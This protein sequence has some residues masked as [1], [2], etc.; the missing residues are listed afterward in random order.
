MQKKKKGNTNMKKRISSLLALIMLVTTLIPAFSVNAAFSDVKDDNAYKEAITTLSVLDVLNGYDDGTFAPEKEITRAEFTTIIVRMLGMGD[1]VETTDVFSD[2]SQEHWANP[3]IK[4]AYDMEIVNGFEDGTFRP[5]SPVTYEE[6]LKMLIHTLKYQDYA[7]ARGGYPEGYRLQGRDMKLTDKI[8][9]VAFNANAPRGVI[10]QVMFNA[11]EIE[12]LEM[13]NNKWVKTG[14]SFLN[15][16]LNAAKIKGTVVGVGESVTAECQA[17]LSPGYMS[18]KEWKTGEEYVISFKEYTGKNVASFLGQEVNVFYRGDKISNDKF[19]IEIDS[20]SVKNAELKLT[21]DD[22]ESFTGGTLR[23]YVDDA[24]KRVSIDTSN[25]SVQYNGKAVAPADIAANLSKWLNPGTDFIYGTVRLVDNGADGSYDLMEIYDYETIV[26][27]KTVSAV[28]Y[29]LTDKTVSG[30][31][32][33]LDPD[34]AAFDFT[35]TKDGKNIEPTAI[36]AGNVVNYATSLDGK[37]V[38]VNVSSEKITGKVTSVNLNSVPNTVTVG[39]KEYNASPRLKDYLTNVEKRDIETG[40]QITAYTDILGAIEWANVTSSETYAPYAYIIDAAED[41]EGSY[42]KLFAPSNTAITS[43]S[44]STAYKVKTF[45]ISTNARLNGLKSNPEN[46]VAQLRTT[47]DRPDSAIAGLATNY[48]DYNQLVKVEFNS[49]REIQNIITLSGSEGSEN[50]DLGKIVR[51]KALDPTKKYKVTSTSVTSDGATLYSLRS[52]T[53]L[54]VIP[55]DRTDTDKYALKSAVSSS[56]LQNNQSYYLDAYDVNT[57]KYPSCLLV[58]GDTSIKKGTVITH[59]TQYS[60]L[61]RTFDEQY[62]AETGEVLKRMYTYNSSS[63]ETITSVSDK[64]DFSALDKGDII[65]YSTDEDKYA[66]TYM[67][68]Q[69]FDAIETVL[70]GRTF[71]WSETQTQTAA[72]NWQKYKFDWRYPKSNITSATDNYYVTDDDTTGIYSRAAMFNVHQVVEDE[73]MLYVSTKGFDAEGNYDSSNYE[74]IKYSSNTLI[75]RYDKDKKE[76]S[77]NIKDTDTK[78]TIDDLYEAVDTGTGC[79]KILITYIDGPYAAAPT[80]KMIV[81]YG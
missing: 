46:I 63:S 69:D 23:Y 81:I 71:D 15:H 31:S 8:T 57:S 55:A 29:K 52:N 4:V 54:F 16:Y 60:L 30:K 11:L 3:Y 5:D 39:G 43:F 75:F 70:N 42:L 26:A 28:D 51:Y 19:L 37:L 62:D 80:A 77:Q 6:A 72:N 48:T 12:E 74:M 68:V 40:V 1:S 22:I 53:P 44:S 64:S 10:A 21:S 2:L 27:Y 56:A 66:D 35:I 61:S 50:V 79:S 32:I 67:L 76:F 25:I 49:D 47:A 18:V 13:I 45:K 59:D 41:G 65:L 20:D 33:V 24:S 34:S 9:G 73:N 78:L 17:N 58:Y 36:V 38:T 7:L 14:R